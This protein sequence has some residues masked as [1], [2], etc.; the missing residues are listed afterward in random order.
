M[1]SE[2]NPEEL[3][4]A[5]LLGKKCLLTSVTWDKTTAVGTSLWTTRFDSVMNNSNANYAGTAKVEI[6]MNL[7]VL[8]LATFWRADFELEF[9]CVRTH[10]HSG[11]LQFTI[12]YGAPTIT[13]ND[14]NVYYN[15]VMDFNGEI[16]RS[17][18][19]VK[20]NAA[21]EFLRTYEGQPVV[22]AVQ[23]YSLGFGSLFIA[24]QLRAPETVAGTVEILIFVRI[25]EANIAVPRPIPFVQM[26]SPTVYQALGPAPAIMQAEGDEAVGMTSDTPIVPNVEAAADDNKIT[27]SATTTADETPVMPL[28]RCQIHA[29]AKFEYPIIHVLDLIRR[30]SFVTPQSVEASVIRFGTFAGKRVYGYSVQPLNIMANFYAAWTGTL[31]YRLFI[32]SESADHQLIDSVYYMPVMPYRV[33]TVNSH[34]ASPGCLV[35]LGASGY[36]I[37]TVAVPTGCASAWKAQEVAYNIDRSTGWIDVSVPYQTHFNFSAL[38]QLTIPEVP[39]DVGTLLITQNDVTTGDVR[40]FMAQAVGDDF[41]YGFFRPP[42]YSTF[43]GCVLTGAPP[44][45]G[46]YNFGGFSV[47]FRPAS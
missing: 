14:R 12:G 33:L 47:D 6:P 42:I 26:T 35:N 5:Y 18:I 27:T 41:K 8:N 19:T 38:K 10:F 25:K 20:Y 43:A 44:V 7:A 31:K 39:E 37:S 13:T 30:H 32:C 46:S 15:T 3:D 24:N 16:D 9:H 22:D 34:L 45:T 28:R 17:V 11:R 1:D 4:L 23:N 29:G 36:A 2:F 40:Q 21:T